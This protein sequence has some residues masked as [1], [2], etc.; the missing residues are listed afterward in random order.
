MLHIKKLV[1]YA[2]CTPIIMYAMHDEGAGT[3]A[4]QQQQTIGPQ[5]MYEFRSTD[6]D[7]SE[8]SESLGLEYLEQ[9]LTRQLILRQQQLA[10]AYPRQSQEAHLCIPCVGC[11]RTVPLMHRPCCDPYHGKYLSRFQE[12]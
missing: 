9:E 5:M 3:S 1:F 8:D 7:G 11:G 2:V 10:L 4:S 6:N 12:P